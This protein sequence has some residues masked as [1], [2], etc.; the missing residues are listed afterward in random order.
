MGIA[1]SNE[2]V[3]HG[4][5]LETG[6]NFAAIVKWVHNSGNLQCNLWFK[7]LFDRGNSVR[8]DRITKDRR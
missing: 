6:M 3:K 7:N 1:Y 8:K 2:H 5:T 4:S